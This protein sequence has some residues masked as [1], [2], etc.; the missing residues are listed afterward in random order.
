MSIPFVCGY[1]FDI[2]VYRWNMKEILTTLFNKYNISYDENKLNK[3]EKFYNIV[4]KQ[5]EVMNLTNITEKNE[6]AIK[7]ILDSV[8]PINAFPQNATVVDVGAGAGFPSIP[9]KI[10][11][12]DL[13]IVMIDSLNKRVKF[14]NDTVN[15]LK[16]NDIQAVHIRAEDFSAN[17]REK[18]D[19]VTARAVKELNVLLEI[20]YYLLKV[21]GTFYAY[22]ASNIDN[23]IENAKH[24]FKCL[25]ID[26]CNK[27][28]Y[29][30]P[31]SKD[32]P[33]ELEFHFEYYKFFQLE[34][35]NT[36][37]L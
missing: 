4:L 8:L 18:F 10:L 5:N 23:E 12:P 13:K 17:N 36:I 30:L 37:V 29:N 24:A 11:R 9:L 25:Q 32:N 14:L 26:G 31:K 1:I 34:N 22:K 20:S 28:E 19:I 3:L 35:R 6:F 21:G 2:I 7:N 33:P 16:L 27:I 15:E